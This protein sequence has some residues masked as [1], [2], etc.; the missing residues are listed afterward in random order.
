[1]SKRKM[2]VKEKILNFLTK[3]E[4]YNTLT[5]AQAVARFGAGAA[6][7]IHELRL[8]GNAIYSNTKTYKGRKI[9]VYRMGTPSDRFVRNLEAGRTRLAVRALTGAAA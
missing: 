5:R 7:R 1:M 9:R 2:S 3:E 6:A 8:E 4:G